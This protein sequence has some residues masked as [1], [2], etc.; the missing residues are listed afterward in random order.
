MIAAEQ[1]RRIDQVRVIDGVQNVLQ[2]HVRAQHSRGIGRHLKF[3]H[4]SALN[5]HAGDAIQ[6]IQPRLQI[7]GRKFP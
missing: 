5:Q 3:R 1:A 7:I 4:L 2:R 6:P